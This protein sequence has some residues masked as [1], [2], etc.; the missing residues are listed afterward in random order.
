[1]SRLAVQHAPSIV[2]IT[3]LFAAFSG[4]AALQQDYL[5]FCQS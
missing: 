2:Y 3:T 5:D 1:M 4:V